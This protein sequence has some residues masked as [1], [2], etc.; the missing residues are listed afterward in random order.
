MSVT[1]EEFYVDVIVIGGGP[2][3]MTAALYASRANLRTVMIEKGIP[4]GE[5]N[6]TADVENYP[7]YSKISGPELAA[8]IYE[9]AMSFGA[10]HITANV[11]SLE[12]HN[13]EKYVQT[14]GATYI[15]PVVI[16]ATGSH[17]RQLGVAGEE[18]LSG[19]G[20]SYCA[21]CDGFFFRNR[22][23][24][25]VGG[26]DSAVEEGVYLTQFADKVTIIHRRDEL[27]AQQILQDRAFNNEKINFIW[28]SIVEE[29]EGDFS[30]KGVQLQNLKTAERSFLPCEGVFIYIGLIPNSEL[31]RNL[32]VTDEEGW[33]VTNERMETTIPGLYAVGDVRQT[34]LRQIATAVGDGSH[35]G[36]MAYQYIQT[37][38]DK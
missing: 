28:D 30:V 1:Q 34:H 36:H 22:H 35:A 21:V 10:E 19:Q 16:M 6:N 12:I 3:G 17:H 29:I 7:G 37:L 8:K 33:I 14:E 15:A 25:V 18:K 20:V 11:I 9:G 4:G 24:V 5:V 13:E 2:A 26:G 31:V 38:A 23:L 32:G 27:R